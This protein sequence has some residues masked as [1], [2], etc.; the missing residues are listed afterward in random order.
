MQMSVVR[1]IGSTLVLADDT[2]IVTYLLVYTVVNLG[3]F[4]VI[5][6]VSRRTRSGELASWGGLFTY[7]PGLAVSSLT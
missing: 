5:I 7:A 4:A 6:T 3:A 2:S 1:L